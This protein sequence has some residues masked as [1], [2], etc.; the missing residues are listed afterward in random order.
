MAY[1]PEFSG[2]ALL[3]AALTA[4][5]VMGC[6]GGGDGV[7]PPPPPPPPP[8]VVVSST[9]PAL[10]PR[11]TTL[12][13]AVIGSGFDQ[14]SRAIWARSGDTTFA[15][16]K[17]KTNST[18]YLSSSELRA[19]ITIGAEAPRGGYDVLVITAGGA[20]GTGLH[21]AGV[22]L[23]IQT[24]DLA[25]GDNSVASGVNNLGQIVGAR[26]VG[27]VQRAFLW[28]N[29][30][31]QDLGVLPGTTTS[32]ARRINERS[33]VVGSTGT[34]TTQRGY[35]WTSAAGMQA[36]LTSAGSSSAANAINDNGDIVGS[37]GTRAVMWRNGVVTDLHD[38]SALSVA[39]ARAWDINNSGAVVGRWD[40]QGFT[41]TAATG[42]RLISAAGSA[43]ESA[44]AINDAGHIGGWQRTGNAPIIAALW[45]T[46]GA[47]DLGTLGG[48]ELFAVNTANAI[49]NKEQVVGQANTGSSAGVVSMGAFIWTRLDQMLSLSASQFNSVAF[50][51]NGKGWVVG[52]VDA[53][54]GVPH[55]TLWKVR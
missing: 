48:H 12:D 43:L 39:D 26:T 27:G 25:A 9:N 31:F 1:S 3:G 41:W 50:D 17:V 40:T 32:T 22:T 10:T 6:G 21:V 14:G 29:G 37:D 13:V 36:L 5:W 52:S 19:N 28:E 45:S 34:G 47:E 49:N 20:K 46:G 51:I 8:T 15:V 18:A 33:E 54:A 30:T 55:A 11:D 23:L 44:Q 53:P 42:M 2:R 16:T 7:T 38:G 4:A 35:V 24:I